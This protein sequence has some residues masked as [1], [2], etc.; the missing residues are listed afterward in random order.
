MNLIPII[1]Y[2]V[3]VL[4]AAFLIRLDNSKQKCKENCIPPVFCLF[5]LLTVS[6]M[7][8]FYIGY[9]LN[10]KFNTFFNFTDKE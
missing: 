10:E 2:T 6:V 5:S 4:I 7:T 8:M 3:G 1:T 9:L